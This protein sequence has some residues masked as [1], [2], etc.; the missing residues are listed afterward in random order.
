MRDDPRWPLIVRGFFI[1]IDM[2]IWGTSP[3][4]NE[5]ADEWLYDFGGNDFRLID[6]TLAGVAAMR[7]VEELDLLEACEVLVAAECVAAACGIPAREIPEE[8]Q[9]W[10]DEHNPAPVNPKYIEMAIK[11]VTKVIDRSELRDFW[12]ES[13]QYDVWKTAVTNLQFRLAQIPII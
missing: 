5:A 3:F 12:A 7:A 1:E 11:A 4:E 2:N 13:E 6:R 8:V 10:L 9:E